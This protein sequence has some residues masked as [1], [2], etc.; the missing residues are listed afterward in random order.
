[1]A[2][3]S[4]ITVPEAHVAPVVMKGENGNAIIWL[5]DHQH[6]LRS[7]DGIQSEQS[8]EGEDQEAAPTPDGGK[9]P[10]LDQRRPH[11][12]EL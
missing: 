6:L 10:S 3:R 5:V 11:G 12:G 4:V 1:M 7:V 8:G 2:V 9:R